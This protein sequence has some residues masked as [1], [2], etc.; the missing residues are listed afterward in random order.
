MLVCYTG[1]KKGTGYSMPCRSH[2]WKD[3]HTKLLQD[4]LKTVNCVCCQ[5]KRTFPWEH[6]LNSYL[7]ARTRKWCYCH[8][9]L[10]TS[11]S[12]AMSSSCSQG[13]AQHCPEDHPGTATAQPQHL[14]NLTALWITNSLMWKWCSS[15]G[16]CQLGNTGKTI[17]KQD[18]RPKRDHS[19]L[20]TLGEQQSS[21]MF[22]LMLF[23]H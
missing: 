4:F 8:E 12:V 15:Q 13:V 2:I 19:Y 10:P 3:Y 20:A 22:L 9:E 18:N 23:I 14:L 11:S 16:H 6:L 7:K 21:C 17:T 1:S 5:T